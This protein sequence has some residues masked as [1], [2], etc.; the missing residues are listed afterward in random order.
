M[1]LLLP[2]EA[3]AFAAVLQAMR[4]EG[5]MPIRRPSW[6][7]PTYWSRPLTLTA[8]PALAPTPAVVPWVDV[9]TWTAPKQYMSVITGFVATTVT[10]PETAN[11]SFQLVVDGNPISG[12]ELAA[13]ANLFKPALYPVIQRPIFTTIAE[14]QTIAI[15]AHNFGIIPQVLLLSLTGWSYDTINSERG[16]DGS[17]SQGITDD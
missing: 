1:S 6:E 16:S 5:A 17:G 15:Q 2:H 4:D 10:N 9:L 14:N 12:V 8:M 3:V 7:Q 13:A 11:V